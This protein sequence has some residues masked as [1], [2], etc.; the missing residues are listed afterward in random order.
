MARPVRLDTG[1]K[2]PPAGRGR[3][4]KRRDAA[5][6]YRDIAARAGRPGGQKKPAPVWGGWWLLQFDGSINTQERLT[7]RA[8]ADALTV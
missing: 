8:G 6:E 4:H 2:M 3:P 1:A 7:V 5:G